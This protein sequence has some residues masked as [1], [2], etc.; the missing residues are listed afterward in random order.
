MS[1]LLTYRSVLT[2]S[3]DKGKVT[4]LSKSDVIMKYGASPRWSLFKILSAE[5]NNCDLTVVRFICLI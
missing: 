5:C 2:K 1:L 3:Q 4:S